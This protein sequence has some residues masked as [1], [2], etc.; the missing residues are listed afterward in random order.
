M[1]ERLRLMELRNRTLAEQVDATRKRH[2]EQMRTL[3]NEMSLLRQ[4][5]ARGQEKDRPSGVESGGGAAPPAPKPGG[6][7]DVGGAPETPGGRRS[8]V[9]GYGVSGSAAEKKTPLKSQFG[10][11]FEWLSE[12]GE[13]QLQFHQETQFDA[14]E[15]APGGDPYARSGFAFPRVRA[16]FNGRLTKPWEYTF[17]LNRGL[18][19][20]DVLD[21]YLNY[22]PDDRAAE[23]RTVHDAIQLRAVRHPEHV[24]VRPPSGRCSRPTWA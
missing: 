6:G 22:H 23:G 21:A 2:E 17:A 1:E 19:N 14:K 16:F 9:P 4:Q 8:P 3:L 15:F 18:G 10:P 13:F 7:P 5:L 11:G 24:A 20:I 12:D